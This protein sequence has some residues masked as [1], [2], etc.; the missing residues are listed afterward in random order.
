M[1]FDPSLRTFIK[2][3]LENIAEIVNYLAKQS[4]G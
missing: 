1:L 4:Y 3:Y 2:G